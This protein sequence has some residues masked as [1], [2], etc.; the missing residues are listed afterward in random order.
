MINVST[1][2]NLF[3]A[4]ILTIALSN[5]GNHGY[6]RSIQIGASIVSTSPRHTQSLETLI[7]RGVLSTVHEGGASCLVGRGVIWVLMNGALIDVL[8]LLAGRLV[9]VMLLMQDSILENERATHTLRVV[10]I[11]STS[12]ET[13]P[14]CM[15]ALDIRV[16]S[17]RQVTEL[18]ILENFCL[19]IL[20]DRR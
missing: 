2:L 18:R 5:R 10:L 4:R 3:I 17:S 9:K 13:G 7:I 8:I 1:P 6:C 20:E 19:L 16:C 14:S 15:P 11:V 12:S